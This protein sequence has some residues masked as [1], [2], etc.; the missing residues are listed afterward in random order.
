MSINPTSGGPP[1][2]PEANRL[3]GT[4]ATPQPAE[5]GNAGSE[6]PAAAQAAD[7]LE[8]SG[9]ARE[10]LQRGA[11]DSPPAS[12]LPPE[13][14]KQ[15]AHRIAQGHYDRPEVQRQMLERIMDVLQRGDS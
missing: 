4:A 3:S 15:I 2:R 12:Q 11:A 9:A 1:P 10:L 8:L 13:R 5:A 7:G 6:Q 14:L